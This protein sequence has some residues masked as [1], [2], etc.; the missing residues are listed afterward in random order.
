MSEGSNIFDKLSI[1]EY[2]EGTG[3]TAK[4]DY[5]DLTD[6]ENDDLEQKLQQ[7][8]WTMGLAGEAGELTDLIKKETFHGHDVPRDEKIDEAGDILWYLTQFL[9]V[10]DI[11]LREV[12]E[13]NLEKLGQRYSDGFSKEESKNREENS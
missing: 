8:N 6:L 3:K 12:M 5:S 1:E 11:T 10:N 13:Y 4:N 7:L 2:Q 9:I